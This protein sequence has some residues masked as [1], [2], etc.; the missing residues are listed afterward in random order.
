MGKGR[1]IGLMKDFHLNS[2]HQAISPLV[3]CFG[4]TYAHH[5]LVRT[6][7]G[8]TAQA[9]AE[10]EQLTK[11]FNPNY[12]FT[13]HFLDEAYGKLYQSEQ[14]VSSLV[15][16]FGMLAIL[17]SCL[18]LFGLVAF[19]AEQRTKEIGIRK[20]LGA[21]IQNIIGLL[22]ADFLRLVLI[23]LVLAAP[24]AWWAVDKWLKTFEYRQELSWWIVALA[25]LLAVGI[26]LLTVSFQSIR[27]ALM[28]PVKSL[29]SE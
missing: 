13:Y 22:S 6:R 1:I 23:A 2:L 12:P 19:T 11:R 14:Q 9:M 8:Q 20:V 29:R 28:N 5:I 17:I 7:A 26:A 18:G 21:S 15:N 16:Y 27:A 4:S 10:L 3:V 25:G 24:V